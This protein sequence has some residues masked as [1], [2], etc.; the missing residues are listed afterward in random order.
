M[1]LSDVRNYFRIIMDGL[2]FKEHR[3]YFNINNIPENIID[4]AYHLETGTISS[5]SANQLVHR[6]EF[7]IIVR[8]F[9]R[10]FN[11]TVESHEEVLTSIDLINASI[12]QVTNRTAGVLFDV[13]PGPITIIPISD[14]ND[15]LQIAECSYTA[16][17]NSCFQ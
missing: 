17:I 6:Y 16:V 1:E 10:G 8:I 7:P 13:V 3:D 9:R 11:D 14:S 15:N 4:Q 12:L 2:G 5:G